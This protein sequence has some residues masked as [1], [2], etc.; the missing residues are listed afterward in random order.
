MDGSDAGVEKQTRC[1]HA[2]ISG[3]IGTL[4]KIL[5]D[6]FLPAAKHASLENPLGH[7]ELKWRRAPPLSP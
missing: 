1:S 3:E 5:A 7:S 2:R 4:P 6:K